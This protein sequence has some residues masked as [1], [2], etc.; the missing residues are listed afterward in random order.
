MQNTC[1]QAFLQL[2]RV[3]SKAYPSRTE[4]PVDVVWQVW[5]FSDY[6]FQLGEGGCLAVPLPCCVEGYLAFSVHAELG[7]T[8]SLFCSLRCQTKCTDDFDKDPINRS[9]LRGDRDTMHAS[10]TQQPSNSTP[11]IF[12]CRFKGNLRRLFL[13]VDNTCECIH[14][15]AEPLNAT[16]NIAA[17]KT[18]NS[19]G[20]STHL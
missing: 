17:K 12:R 13:K 10:P 16:R 20:E 9:N 19:S 2:P 6:A 4:S 14:A 3:S 1:L 7:C 15:L 18:L 5:G 8:W 11:R